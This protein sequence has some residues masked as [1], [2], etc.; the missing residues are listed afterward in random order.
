MISNRGLVPRTAALALTLPGSEVSLTT[1]LAAGMGGDLSTLGLVFGLLIVPSAI[2]AL[3]WS[4]RK[5]TAPTF[6]RAPKLDDTLDGLPKTGT[7][8]VLLIGPP[9]TRKDQAVHDYLCHVDELR[10]PDRIRLLDKDLTEAPEALI[11]TEIARIEK[12]VAD[13]EAPIGPDGRV[14]SRSNLEVN[15]PLL[16]GFFALKLLERMTDQ[17]TTLASAS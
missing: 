7:E 5:L 13:D 2:F 15:W 16:P 10:T 8:V 1:K 9:R 11:A 4:R 17:S 3:C 12:L 14:A 6:L